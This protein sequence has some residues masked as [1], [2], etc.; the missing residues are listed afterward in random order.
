[1]LV[2]GLSELLLSCQKP[3]VSR[4]YT[5]ILDIIVSTLSIS[6]NQPKRSSKEE[7]YLDEFETIL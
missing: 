7:Q 1:M 6:D 2:A 3:F 5:Q 4:R